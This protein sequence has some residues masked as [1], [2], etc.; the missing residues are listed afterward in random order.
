MTKEMSKL[1]P[2]SIYEKG[3]DLEPYL[4]VKE[5]AWDVDNALKVIDF[6]IGQK[7]FILGGDV[8]SIKNQLIQPTYDSWYI[9]K[10]ECINDINDAGNKAKE[11]ILDYYKSNGGNYLYSIVLDAYE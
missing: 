3:I 8:Y 11:Y 5:I 10:E 2:L 6:L 4:G 7:Y 1:V 9:L